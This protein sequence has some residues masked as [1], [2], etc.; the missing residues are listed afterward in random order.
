VATYTHDENTRIWW[1]DTVAD[2]EAPTAAEITAATELTTT[3]SKD[4]LKI[5]SSNNIV[6]NDNISTSFS[7]EIPGTYGNKLSL[8]CFR[9]DSTDDT[10]WDT[11]GVRNTH[12]FLIVRRAKP[13]TTAVVVA[14]KVEVYP[15]ITQQPVI[16]DSAEN[17]RVMVQY[18]LAVPEAP[19]LNAAVAA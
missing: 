2:I 1:A 4:G 12:G 15:A 14:D 8:K 6:K 17:A 16:E 13:F 11:L 7:G 3:V 9:G 10:A 18:D 19:A 5:G